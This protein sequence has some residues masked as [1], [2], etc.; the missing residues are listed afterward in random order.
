[1]PASPE[2][3]GN[4]HSPEASDT[5]AGKGDARSPAPTHEI[6]RT[7]NDLRARL[8][9]PGM[10]LVLDRN[11]LLDKSLRGDARRRDYLGA[12][13]SIV[14]AS[15]SRHGGGHIS[16]TIERLAG[17]T[18]ILSEIKHPISFMKIDDADPSKISLMYP[19]KLY[20]VRHDALAQSGVPLNPS[21]LWMSQDKADSDTSPSPVIEFRIV[22]LRY[23]FAPSRLAENHPA[24]TQ[25]QIDAQAKAIEQARQ[26]KAEETRLRL[27]AKAAQRQIMRQIESSP[28]DKDY[29]AFSASFTDHLARKINE[30]PYLISSINSGLADPQTIGM[31]DFD[32]GSYLQISSAGMT[33]AQAEAAVAQAPRGHYCVI[34]G[35]DNASP[36]AAK[37]GEALIYVSTGRRHAA[38]GYRAHSDGACSASQA[39]ASLFSYE[40]P[41]FLFAA[42]KMLDALR[43]QQRVDY[44]SKLITPGMVFKN[45][46]MKTNHGVFK[47]I[48]INA[49]E[50]DGSLSVK[51]S[52]PGKS[53]TCRLQNGVNDLIRYLPSIPLRDRTPL[54]PP[55]VDSP[56]PLS[57][58]PSPQR[59]PAK[60]EVGR[61][62]QTPSQPSMF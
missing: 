1:M 23:K 3:S 25:E 41:S 16:I 12:P 21:D 37:T 9:E 50:D 40:I 45:A 26:E 15:V 49:I 48:T 24:F 11:D 47:T 36:G 22:D 19:N 28:H 2:I 20:G 13:A 53:A 14:K 39:Q 57:S 10:G 56:N 31:A 32:Y 17:N 52:R 43:D 18:P 33:D 51:L 60:L 44:Y 27:A 38:V 55:K 30:D 58:T 54:F 4:A 5:Q 46:S 29:A 7:L 42:N 34:L 59:E 62:G 35:D 61:P 6:S 8:K